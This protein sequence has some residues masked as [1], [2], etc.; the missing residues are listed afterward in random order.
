MSDDMFHF[1][2]HKVSF[3]LFIVWYRF[4]AFLDLVPVSR[5]LSTAASV[6]V[7]FV[8]VLLFNGE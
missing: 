8:V 6:F 1:T 5:V 4:R 2:G 7:V 3:W